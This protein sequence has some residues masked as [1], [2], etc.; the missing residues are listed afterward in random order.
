MATV[1]DQPH[2]TQTVAAVHS[3]SAGLGRQPIW[4]LAS[5]DGSWDRTVAMRTADDQDRTPE[6]TTSP[7]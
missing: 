3:G 1:V 7:K 6:A 5:S 2:I 4:I